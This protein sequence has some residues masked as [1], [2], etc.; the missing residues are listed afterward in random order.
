MIKFQD[1]SKS[2]NKLQVFRDISFEIKAH[3]VVAVQGSSGSGKT[4]LLRLIAGI[5]KPDSGTIQVHSNRVG[6]IFQ[7]HRL[8]PWRTAVENIA[9]V[10]KARGTEPSKAHDTAC[11]WM[12]R[13]GLKGFYD[14]YPS[15]LSG[16]MVQRI[17]IA[18][19][20][21]IQPDVILMDEPF[22]SLD[23]DLAE[24]LLRETK[25]I[26]SE[27]KVTAV[28][29]THRRLEVLRIADR[30][31]QISGC[32]MQESTVADRKAMLRDYLEN[33]MK[34]IEQA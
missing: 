28:Y 13:M 26:L 29:V 23:A 11:L 16:G 22:S 5:L 3:E 34:D 4:T 7:D 14:Y 30:I 18:R 9:L 12:D 8:L 17:S 20:F 1:V 21:S 32:S 10:L 33:R 24:S 2:F 31:F 6:F 15:Q 25:Q 27:S 19:A